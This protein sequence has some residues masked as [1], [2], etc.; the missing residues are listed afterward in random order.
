MD[1]R[2]Y[3]SQQIRGRRR[4]EERKQLSLSR[5]TIFGIFT[6]R[7]VGIRPFVERLPL[8]VR[9]QFNGVRYPIFSLFAL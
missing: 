2:N 1:R 7:V 5:L 6:W 3:I 4:F 9:N 8:R